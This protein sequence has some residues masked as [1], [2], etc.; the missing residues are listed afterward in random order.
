MSSPITERTP[1][2]TQ[3]NSSTPTKTRKASGSSTA[4]KVELGSMPKKG[5]PRKLQSKNP[6]PIQ[7]EIVQKPAIPSPKPKIANNEQRGLASPVPKAD[8]A[9]AS[10]SA[11]PL[12]NVAGL[13]GKMTNTL[14]D[15]VK[16]TVQDTAQKGQD[17][18]DNAIPLDLSSLK[19]LE[20]GEG[21]N[22]FDQAGNTLGQ[23]VEGESD[24]LVGQVIG[25]DG[26]ILDEDGD[27][28]G[29]VEVLPNA[30]Q[31]ATEG[32][33]DIPNQVQPAVDQ[34]KDVAANIADL[35]GL[36]ISEGGVIKNA[37]GKVIGK[38]TKGDP[39]YLV[40]YTLND[41]GEVLDDDGDLIG[42]ADVLPE[43]AQEA[44]GGVKDTEESSDAPLNM[45]D[46]TNSVAEDA[47]NEA[48]ESV[49][50]P[51]EV[52]KIAEEMTEDAV[53][54]TENLPPLSTLEGLKC[55]KAG[56][57]VST[58]T[59]RPMGE[60]IEGDAKKIT[61]LGA[62]LDDK[63]QF[64]DGRGNVIG[65]AQTI[66]LDEDEEEPPFAGLE[67]LH[68]V[69]DGWIEDENEKRV[70]RLIE[71]DAKKLL[72]RA[73]DEDGDV[74]DK[75]GNSIAKA[76]Y[77]APPDEEV[78]DLSSLN[79]LIPNK[80]GYV[81]GPKG[82]PIA[83]VVDGNLKEVAGKEIDD[84]QIYDGRKVIGRV[85][86][87]PENE[88]ENKPEGPFAGLDNLVVN[89]EGLVEDEDGNIIGKITEGDHKKLRGRIVDEDGDIVDKFGSVKGHAEPYEPPEEE[90]EE[91]DLS[92]LEG[93]MVNKAGNVV[94]AQGTVYGRITS[95][96]K[97]LA[98]RKV[99]GQGQIWSDDG[100]VIGKADLI[101]G[102][103]Q[104]KTEGPFYGF[105]T[106]EVGKDGTVADA[107]GRI[108]GRL[109]E[110]DPK[111][112]LGRKVDEDGDVL[113]KNGNSIGKAERWEPEE[114]KRSVNPMS[115][116]K[117]TREGEVRD[118]DGNLIGKLTSGNL[119]TL[120]GKEIDDNGYVVD[121]DGNKM[122]EPSPEE[123]EAQKQAAED[124]DLANKMSS[125]VG[126]AMG[127]LRPICNMITEHIEKADRTPRDELDEEKLVQNVKPL[128]EQGNQ[129]LQECNG[130]IRALDP[131]GHIAATAKARAASHEAS[132]EE[133][134]LADQLKE[135]ADFVMKTIEN[136]RRLIAD[137][138]HA[139]KELNPLWALLSEPLFQIITAVGLLLTGVLGLVGRLLEGLGLGP[140]VHGLL[141]GLGIDKLLG[142]LGLSSVTDAL[143][144]TG[145]KQ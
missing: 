31:D 21:G 97:R 137:M 64:W 121:N 9:Q 118:S 51:D 63:G 79:G 15:Q 98:G 117:V 108:I 40:G 33:T 80:L 47:V 30:V 44:L 1:K 14:T 86:L 133:Y 96:D 70:G 72:G 142:S 46:N 94:D 3:R 145:K 116:R 89:K 24:D 107:S 17:V 129:V 50:E 95:G 20:V 26:K 67:G 83:R 101:H 125:I 41:E 32:A 74:I 12:G 100:K 90:V 87:I 104:E 109:I 136:G 19:G 18:V 110:G 128:L 7:D 38:I 28:I 34:V 81:V 48:E 126:H 93:K 102:S 71:G 114:K 10:G 45:V 77:W 36:P 144:L 65:K 75:F 112:L 4:S 2:L 57:I 37:A 135:M 61:K 122:G 92:S 127:S 143:G 8:Q 52:N 69:E 16:D 105:E 119:G 131:D 11:T 54:A 13:A 88:R 60:L 106:A 82:V 25:D 42:R 140:I 29:R 59:G 111:R 27:L 123:L 91:V 115:G 84:G 23:V 68:V 141:G 55:N 73:V 53:E 139:K 58:S 85:E 103:E 62:Q 113:G 43:D 39:E 130:A 35:D 120:V 66:A 138:P 6:A 124:R 99:D 134:G 49:P 56:N 76:E 22:I 5:S 132:P 78:I